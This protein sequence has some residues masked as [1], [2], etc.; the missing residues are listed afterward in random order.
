MNGLDTI[1]FK[2]ERK[3]DICAEEIS[4]SKMKNKSARMRGRLLCTSSIG[5][6]TGHLFFVLFVFSL[7]IIIVVFMKLPMSDRYVLTSKI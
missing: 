1:F 6:L 2:N 3:E 5:P 4:L 7:L